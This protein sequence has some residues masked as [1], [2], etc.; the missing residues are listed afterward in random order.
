MADESF[1]REYRMTRGADFDQTFARRCSMA[2]P[3]LIV[4]AMRNNLPHARLGMAVS[5]KVG[6]AVVRNRWKRMLRNAFRLEKQ[7]LPSGVDLLVLPRRG[8][9]PDQRGIRRSLCKLAQK[10]DR[11]LE[12]DAR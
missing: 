12:R 3:L 9:E 2:D 5:K 11:R 1:P 7:R 8:A 4:Y 6:N 10:L